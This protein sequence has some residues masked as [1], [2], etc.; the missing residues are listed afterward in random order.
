MK[1]HFNWIV[2][3]HRGSCTNPY[4]HCELRIPCETNLKQDGDTFYQI[5][6]KYP[7][8]FTPKGTGYC[9]GLCTDQIELK[10]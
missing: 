1:V 5:L 3:T 6:Q 8:C 4:D 7:G 2:N 9:G 10:N